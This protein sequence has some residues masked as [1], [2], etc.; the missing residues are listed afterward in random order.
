MTS[1]KK[2]KI[3]ISICMLFCLPAYFL[4]QKK[5][6]LHNAEDSSRIKIVR[7]AI[8]SPEPDFCPFMCGRQLYYLSSCNR[9]AAV[10][11]ENAG[12][13]STLIDILSAKLSDSLE[14]RT[15][16]VAKEL[17]SRYNDGPF[18]FSASGN[19][20]YFTAGDKKNKLKIFKSTKTHKGWSKPQLLSFCEDEFNYCHPSISRDGQ[21]LAFSS[22]I[23]GGYGGMDIYICRLEQG[24]WG[25]PLN[26]G[27]S[28]NTAADELFPFAGEK[29]QIYFSSERDKNSGGL[30]IYSANLNG[31]ASAKPLPSPINSANDDYGIWLDGS[32]ENGYFSS[33]RNRDTKDDIYYFSTWIPDFNGSKQPAIKNKFCYTFY[34][35]SLAS[36][37][38][39]NAD[40]EWNFGDG[41]R[42]RGLRSRHCYAQPGNYTVELNII[43]KV[44]GSIF[45]N[46][47]TYALN[48]ENPPQLLIDCHDTVPEGSEILISSHR[49]AL[50]GYEIKNAYWSFGDG[51][52]N[53]GPTVRHNY[54]HSGYYDLELLVIAKN[55]KTN[56]AEKFRIGK[57][58]IVKGNK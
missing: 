37:D 42:S 6:A 19:E 36:S 51:K 4:A 9:R 40:F 29:G 1:F 43:E 33:N 31:T 17:S 3:K 5:Q 15:P 52:Y 2:M 23:K 45:R 38:T 46:E 16:Q 10:S 22:D 7:L 8:N 11:Y 48:I 14:F 34:E 27:N 20:F 13:H 47:V 57:R 12:D 55:Q 44:S 21:I 35:E 39:S 53:H 24:Q 54:C 50:K 32:M 30:D 41:T 49:S 58:I 26:A 28:V 56:E 18:C 25:L